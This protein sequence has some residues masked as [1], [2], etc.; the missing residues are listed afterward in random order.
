VSERSE[1]ISITGQDDVSTG[2]MRLVS[3]YQPGIGDG[4]YDVTLN[5][6]V[7]APGATVAPVT[8]R[9][10]VSGPRFALDPADVHAQ[11]PP[12]AASGP[13]ADVLPH[14]V[15]TKRL[16]PWERAC[17]PLPRATPWLALLTF[18]EG[19]LLADPAVDPTKLAISG[20][21]VTTTV[22]E[23]LAEA[24]ATVRVPHVTPDTP[25]EA[26]MSCQVITVDAATFAAIAPTAWE[27]PYL[28]HG[29]DVDAGAKVLLD[30]ADPGQFSVVV[31]NRFALAGSATLGARCIVHLVSL[32]GFA[33]L[34]GGPTPV[35]PP[36]QTV[37]LVS[38]YSW[39]FSCLADPS[40][41]FSGLVQNLA[42]D[43]TGALRPANTLRLALIP[44]QA[45]MPGAAPDPAAVAA[46]RLGDGYIAAGYH[47][48][49]GEDGFAWYRGPC[50]PSV[51]DASLEPGTFAT[52]SSATIFDPDTGVFDHSLA[53]AW[54]CG[55][56]LA[57]AG[58]AFAEALLRLR[59]KARNQLHQQ[60]V[61]GA[62]L[63]SVDGQDGDA[64]DA[65]R[66]LAALVGAGALA[67]IATASS[68]RSL[69]PAAPPVAAAATPPPVS[70]LRR[71]LDAPTT[72]STL[73]SGLADDPDAQSVA[74]WLGDLC[75][76]DGV[77]FN[78]LVADA[79]MLP[80]ETVRWFYLDPVWIAA[81]IDG[82]LTVGLATSEESA[83][84]DALTAQLATMAQAS[85]LAARATAL[86]QPPPAP[87]TGPMSGLLIRSA[88]ATGW[89]GL[90]ISGTANRD[91]VATLRLDV[92]APNVFICLFNGVPDTVTLEQPHEGLAFGVDDAGA[93]V[94]RTVDGSTIVDGAQLVIYDPQNPATPLPSVRSGGQRVLNVNT[95]VNPASTGTDPPA[96]P[97]DLLGVIAQ[98]LQVSPTSITP[99]AFA[100]QMVDG[101]ELLTFSPTPPPKPED[102]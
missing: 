86:G 91:P 102:S 7:T 55:R 15:L 87:C 66:R 10:V 29:R 17:P 65:Y 96:T 38:L 50:T 76:L 84:Q 14:V 100:L 27:L 71:L 52:A 90:T 49:S 1:R 2:Q 95:T 44:A 12:A 98:G 94:M 3:F 42:Y 59:Q 83:V 74:A 22:T 99:A 25:D 47:A 4:S 60:L 31:A 41:T 97:V 34:L 64:F 69:T 72:A 48:R 54:Q 9:F 45:T 89:P 5:Q 63:R 51:P 101:P 36:E 58:Q 57:L 80:A 61:G 43:A 73:S 23:L 20:F 35:T 24:S 6:T 67:S 75:L 26:A 79:R 21:A 39:T 19:E 8:R 82:A 46:I 81:M 77:P 88:L 40:Q 16:L 56:S 37:K 53:A 11:C 33:D 78:H 68:G 70:R 18:Q 13:F 62:D 30:M 92:I 32:E 93:I 85:A 28:A